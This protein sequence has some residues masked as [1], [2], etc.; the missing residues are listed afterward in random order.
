MRWQLPT[1]GNLHNLPSFHFDQEVQQE[2][3][4]TF[5]ALDG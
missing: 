4:K 1:R 3:Q 2:A 5:V